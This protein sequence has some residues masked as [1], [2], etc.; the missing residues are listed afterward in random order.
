MARSSN[1]TIR[2]SEVERTRLE[3]VATK[4]GRSLGDVIRRRLFGPYL[5]WEEMPPMIEA[6]KPRVMGDG[7]TINPEHWQGGVPISSLEGK[8]KSNPQYRAKLIRQNGRNS[9]V[10]QMYDESHDA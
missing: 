4:E 10:V 8:P 5:G 6:P 3:E 2:L 1:F 7:P 9:K